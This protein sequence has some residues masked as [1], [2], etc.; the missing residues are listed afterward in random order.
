MLDVG[1]YMPKLVEIPVLVEMHEPALRAHVQQAQ[2]AH[3][4]AL[5]TLEE[6][7]DDADPPRIAAA[8]QQLAVAEQAANEAAAWAN[9]RD[10]ASHYQRITSHLDELAEARN[11]AARLAKGSIPRWWSV[12]PMSAPAFTVFQ[13]QRGPWGDILGAQCILEA[14]LLAAD[15]RYPLERMVQE[16]VARERGQQRRVLLYVEQ[17]GVRVTA[18]RY[19]EVLAAY[20]PWCLPQM[21]PE[22]RE[23]AIRT[24]VQQGCNV[25]IA[26]YTHVA[27]GLNLQHEFDSVVWVEM[28][29]S[30]FLRD[31]ASRRI[32]RLGKQFNPAI[33]PEAREVRIYYLVY[34]GSGG[35]KKLHKL[36]QQNGAAIL[37][38]GDT[39]DGALV[40]QAGA[41]HTAL[42]KLSR[43]LHQHEA[44]DTLDATFARRNDERFVTLQRG[45]DW[46]GVTDTLPARLAAFHHRRAAAT[47]PLA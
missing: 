33:P 31:Q 1:A 23:D 45:R 26:P 8:A 37:F 40:K 10:L 11:N 35:H 18:T 3:T 30:H 9:A 15:H 32:W 42:A 47:S 14:P 27:E 24:A 25:V 17:N 41:D 2:A 12:L 38:A 4:A 43:D 39:P 29:Q 20:H 19:A 5:A 36:G 16:V 6:A 46:I 7:R 34:K 28:A 13:T 21:D 22:R 44:A